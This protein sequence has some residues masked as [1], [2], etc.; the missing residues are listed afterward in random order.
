MN[1]ISVIV[2]ALSCAHAPLV[3]CS[4]DSCGTSGLTNRCVCSTGA[5]G[6]QTCQPDGAWS[7]CACSETADSDAG[8]DP[9]LSDADEDRFDAESDASGDDERELSDTEFLDL[10][11]IE[12]EPD[13][14][15]ESD[16]DAA[17]DSDGDVDAP[18]CV[19]PGMVSLM[20]YLGPCAVVYPERIVDE[21]SALALVDW[22]NAEEYPDL[23][24]QVWHY[25][26][27]W[28]TPRDRHVYELPLSSN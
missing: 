3:A 10:D 25:K 11:D 23:C 19:P 4:G 22:S 14:W 5:T 7:T 18:L 1:R 13:A 9:T 20:A 21:E 27:D 26:A 28:T 15:C 24:E 8:E 2:I 12:T 6:S 17:L 16:F